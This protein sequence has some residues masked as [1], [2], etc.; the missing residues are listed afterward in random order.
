M[1]S[2]RRHAPPHPGMGAAA[3]FAGSRDATDRWP[4]L[5]AIHAYFASDARR[6]AQTVLGLIWL[7]D[8]A[9][10]FQGFMYSSGFPHM[11]LGMTA[12]QPSW[13]ASSVAWGAHT[14]SH[15]L[16]IYNTLFALVQ[17]AV[18]LGLLYRPTV[19]P[20][21]VLSFVWVPI[22]WWFGEAFGMLFMTMASPLTGA[23]GAVLLYGLV[24]LAVWPSAKPGGL[25]GVR[26]ASVMW[27]AL[28]LVMAYLWLQAPSANPDAISAALRAAPSGMVW[29]SSL[30]IDVANALSGG[31]VAIALVL[32]AVSA[33][34]GIGVAANRRRESVAL[35]VRRAEPRLLGAWS[36]VRWDVPR[37]R[38]RSECG[39]AVHP[40]CVRYVGLIRFRSRNVSPSRSR[41][42]PAT[43]GSRLVL[44]RLRSRDAG[45]IAPRMPF[46]KWIGA[47]LIVATLVLGGCA[48]ADKTAAT[49]SSQSGASA[50]A[51]MNMSIPN[52]NVGDGSVTSTRV[53][54]LSVVPTTVLASTTWQGMRITAQARTALP[55]VVYNGTSEQ[56]IKPGR[57]SSFHLMVML[58]D[59]Q[60]GVAIP[61]AS[62]WATISRAGKV[63]YDERQ[64]AMISRY[65]GPH[66]GND[67]TLPGNG[68]YQLSLLVSPPVA[69]RHMEYANVWTSTASHQLHV[70]LAATS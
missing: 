59:A 62:V 60:T 22:V 67:V 43:S 48:S 21:L 42:A 40:A 27:C 18:G 33:V 54:G 41:A 4:A 13:I 5:A 35:G 8:G 64:W 45:W 63:V 30:Q 26:G 10:Q 38:D 34:I 16:G 55:F 11:L 19:R 15:Q 57:H 46:A 3:R 65:M 29:L 9:L 51:G 31:G 24:G 56:E 58:S 44:E 25:L 36:G 32:S 52:K 68:S 66:Y 1:S 49:T 20:A 37:W 69:A 61:Y 39:T 50:M 28:W 17:V 6:I 14:A 12:G 47:P 23:P 2:T 53:A 70:P 7:L